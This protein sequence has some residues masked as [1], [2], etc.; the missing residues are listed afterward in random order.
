MRFLLASFFSLL[1]L[2]VAPDVSRAALIVNPAQTITQAVTVQIVEVAADD[3][4]NA[5]PL[6]GT[7]TQQAAIFSLVDTIWAQA[8]IDVEFKL[9]TEVWDNS[10]ALLGTPGNNNPRPT[11]DLNTLTSNAA[12][13]GFDD[14]DP[15][16]LNLFMV[17][18]VPG[19]SQSSDNSSN[20]LALVGGNGIAFWAGPNLPSFAAGEEAIASVLAHEIGHNLGL[21]HVVEAFN[22]MQAGGSPNEG[23]QLDSDQIAL[24]LA[25]QYTVPVP[26]MAVGSFLVFGVAGLM[27]AGRFRLRGTV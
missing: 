5:A 16:V 6:F 27:G 23:Q 21:N 11:S 1:L 2:L 25:S 20:G 22:L 12:T 9:R 8:G 14:P 3:G 17:R 19:F 7:P 18:I 13:A 24:A 26:E 10:F 15:L 4:T